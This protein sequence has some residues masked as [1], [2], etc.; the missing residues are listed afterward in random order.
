MKDAVPQELIS[1]LEAASSM[2]SDE[3]GTIQIVSHYDAD[4]ICAA[5]V[6]CHAFIRKKFKFHVKLTSNLKDEFIGLINEDAYPLTIFCDMGSGQL[7]SLSD[8]SGD[9]IILDHHTP[10]ED[11]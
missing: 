6:L 8:F 10:I 7:K 3:N 5:G 1:R 2:V 9:I 4:G 11:T